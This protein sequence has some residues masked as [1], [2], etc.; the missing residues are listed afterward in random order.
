[1]SVWNDLIGFIRGTADGNAQQ[2]YAFA[3]GAESRATRTG[4]TIT[5]DDVLRNPTAMSCINVIS[6]SIAQLDVTVSRKDDNGYT[7][8]PNHP[9]TNLLNRPNILQTRS[10]FIHSILVDTLAHGNAYIL[11][12]GTG[13]GRQL[14]CL[15]P[16][17]ISIEKNAAGRLV[18]VER[19][20]NGD[21][22]EHTQSDII[23]IRDFSTHE[24]LGHSRALLMAEIIA[25]DN[26]LRDLVSEILK[27]GN[28]VSAVLSCPE[29]D[30]KPDEAEK[31]AKA[32]KEKFSGEG[33]DRGG[34]MILSGGMEYTQNQF[35]SVGDA[36]A[37]A[38][39]A[40]LRAKICAGFRVPVQFLELADNNKYNNVSQKKTGF[41]SDTLAP[42]IKY[43]EEK[44][45]LRLLRQ[46]DLYVKFDTSALIKGDLVS[47]AG[48]VSSLRASGLITVNEGRQWLGYDRIDEE[49]ADELP[50][51]TATPSPNGATEQIGG[52]SD[53]EENSE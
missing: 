31:I 23:H 36:Q 33:G 9:I 14:V 28:S 10:E 48:V 39:E 25:Q 35:L 18:Y 29:G 24:E 49:M 8:L 6:D 26:A 42:L 37:I 40:Q 22:R 20:E 52:T 5:P 44:L 13:E 3:F 15:D 38:L 12:V 17:N 51:P 50:Q 19:P 47:Q 21:E 43:L 27:N 11:I 41:Y 45:T 4:K 53:A 16:R 1:M 46:N 7:P 32:W 2:N 34:V 30:I